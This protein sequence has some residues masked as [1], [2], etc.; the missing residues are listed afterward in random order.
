MVQELKDISLQRGGPVSVARTSSSS[1]SSSAA[2][3][4]DSEGL[5][6]PK[7]VPNPCIESREA[8]DLNREIRWNAKT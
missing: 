5:I 7:K 1:S 2:S 4:V 8:M 3:R 6:L